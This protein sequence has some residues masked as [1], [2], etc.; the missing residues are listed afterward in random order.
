MDV[1]IHSAQLDVGHGK[2]MASMLA[3]QRFSL[4]G[5]N[6]H[7]RSS[8]PILHHPH[9]TFKDNLKLIVG[10]IVYPV[11]TRRWRSFLQD[12]PVLVE[13]AQRYPRIIHKIYRPYLSKQLSCA[14][15]VDVLIG[16]YSQVFKAGLRELIHQAALQPVP[17]AEFAGKS[18]AL[19]QLQLSAINVGHRE[20]ELSLQ[21]MFE[22]VNV[23]SASFVLI[24]G[25]GDSHIKLGALQGL[26]SAGGTMIIKRVT[27]ELQGCRPKK[28]VTS[29]VRYIGAYFGC[30]MMLLVSNQN[31]VSI[32]GRRSRRISSNYDET[33]EEMD[34]RRRSD[35]NFELPCIDLVGKDFDLVPSNK[36]S[37]A[38]RRSALIE[39]VGDAIRVSLDIWR[40]P[41]AALIPDVNVVPACDS[42]APPAA[43]RA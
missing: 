39:S 27:R 13:L 35:G 29:M 18:G 40:S 30:S 12:N 6:M 38:R 28:L 26:R 42:F 22:G 14:E 19:F 16:H 8:L 7:T 10:A 15:R 3:P 21:L 20:G 24:S 33:W 17:V 34:A 37:E 32:N 4:S 25:H 36:R 23:Y 43:A 41:E 31:R 2:P 5:K 9:G 1:F 11:Q